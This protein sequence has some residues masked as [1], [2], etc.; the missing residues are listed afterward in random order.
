MKK[1]ISRENVNFHAENIFSQKVQQAFGNT[2]SVFLGCP[3]LEHSHI[4]NL[5]VDENRDDEYIA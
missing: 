5:D 2:P 3:M 1:N 4:L